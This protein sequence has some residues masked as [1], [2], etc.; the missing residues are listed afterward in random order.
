IFAG[1][2][3]LRPAEYLVCRDNRVTISS[4]WDIPYADEK[5]I[6]PLESQAG[7]LRALLGG[8]VKKRL[9]SDV[10]LGVFLSGGIDSSAVAAFMVKESGTRV[11]SFNISF[12][13][14]DYDEAPDARRVASFLG[15][16][17][18]EEVFSPETL[19]RLLPQIADFL[20][21]PLA[22]PSLLPT[23]LLSRFTRNS[24]TVALGGDGGDELFA[25]YPTYLA[26][27]YFG[28]Y[29]GLPGAIK[30]AARFAVS[31]LPVSTGYFSLDFKAKRFLRGD[32]HPLAGRHARWMSAF[33]PE[34][35][36]LLLSP[37]VY[38]SLPV[39]ELYAELARYDGAAV[40][41]PVE[42][43]MYL[44]AK[45]Y[46]QDDVLAKVDRASMAV[47]LEVRAPFLDRSVVEFA[48]RLPLDRKLRGLTSKFIL[49]RAVAG[50]LPPEVIRK[51]KQGFSLPLSRWFRKELSPLLDRYLNAE[52]LK[53]EGIFQPEYVRRI[54]EEHR[55]G[56]RDHR[57]MLWALLIFELWKEHYGTR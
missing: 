55:G 3:K 2:R 37:G 52:R 42:K 33:L 5:S 39:K 45:M 46:L 27:R 30:N 32:G 24:V 12:S 51:K 25:G 22:D 44:D 43:A 14:K 21:E 23:Y 48:A 19:P 10:P 53:K 29:A 49:R 50:L 31:R 13:E 56:V 15:T 35:L 26:H 47:S 54:V 17:H 11:R 6:A 40:K 57:K 38:S 28:L 9:V 36:S 7:E 1:I 4:Y 16:E 20:D 8:A 18:H 41:D 34:E